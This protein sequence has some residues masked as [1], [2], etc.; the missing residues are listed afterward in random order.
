MR[1]GHTEAATD[2]A[3]LAGLKPAGVICEIM[4]DD[5]S[6]ARLPDL[7]T[8][9]QKH[10]LKI[11]TISDLIAYRRRHDNLVKERSV[12]RVSS[13]H[14]GEWL[15]R[16][17]SDVAQGSEHVVLTKGDIS[18]P[19]PVLVRMHALDP[20]ADVLGIGGAE[21]TGELSGA[22]RTIA[23]EGRGVVVL[24]RD[25]QMKLV[26]GAKPRR[27][28]CASMGLARRSWR[29]WA[30]RTSRWSPITRRPRSWGWMPMAC[31]SRAPARLRS[32]PWLP[33]NN[34]TRWPCRSSTAR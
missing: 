6:M 20:L 2:V 7:V 30:C 33:L 21:T 28:R 1:A 29:R 22:M 34:T 4:N 9:A 11:G 8:F 5:G 23:A 14:G 32:E 12:K 26:E 15:M 31:R 27:R 18:S 17:F 16:I 3:R 10:G 19:E 13:V 24:L 25:T